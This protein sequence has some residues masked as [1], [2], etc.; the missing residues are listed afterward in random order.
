MMV[1]PVR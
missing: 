1:M